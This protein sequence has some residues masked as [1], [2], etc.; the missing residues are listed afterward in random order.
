M[1]TLTR[2]EKTNFV[3]CLAVTMSGILL[4]G[5]FYAALTRED[6]QTK[7]PCA[8]GA[9]IIVLIYLICF[10]SFCKDRHDERK[11]KRLSRT[12]SLPKVKMPTKSYQ[13]T[14]PTDEVFVD[15]DF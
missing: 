15:V 4:Y 2:K 7:I 12:P 9:G 13:S 3:Y 5:F 14:P 10:F 8:I 11:R 1:E 6:L